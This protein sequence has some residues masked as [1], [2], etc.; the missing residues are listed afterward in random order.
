MMAEEVEPG[1]AGF[2]LYKSYIKYNRGYFY[3]FLILLAKIF[4][5]GFNSLTN[6]WLASWTES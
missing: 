6:L 4:W 3:M 2:E 5:M 1:D